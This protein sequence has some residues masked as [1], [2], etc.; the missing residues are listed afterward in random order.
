MVPLSEHTF[1]N[2]AGTVCAGTVS[3]MLGRTVV[4]VITETVDQGHC[5]A[6]SR[7]EDPSRLLLQRFFVFV[8]KYIY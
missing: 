5:M 6:D 4:S 3:R 1:A 8:F 2:R 7:K